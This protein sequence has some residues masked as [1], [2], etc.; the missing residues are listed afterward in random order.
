MVNNEITDGAA[1]KCKKR[2]HSPARALLGRAP[3]RLIWL[4]DSQ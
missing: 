2:R 1:L 3:T 4:P